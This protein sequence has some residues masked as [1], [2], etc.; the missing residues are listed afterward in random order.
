LT[1][2]ISFLLGAGASFPYGVPMMAG[3]YSEFRAHVERRHSHCFAL[4]R[5]LEEHGGHARPDLETLLSDLQAVAGVETGLSAMGKDVSTLG[6]IAVARELRGYLDAFI[7]DQCERFDRERVSRELATLF[8]LRRVA[9]VWIFSTNYDRIVEYACEANGVSWSDGFQ[10]G[11]PQAVV[12]WCGMFDQ[13]IRLVKLHGSVNWYEDDPG[14][15]LHRLDRGYPLPAYDFRLLRG[16]QV[17]R[18]LMIIPT[19]E[20][21][22]LKKPYVGLAMRFTDLLKETR[23]LIVAGNSLRDQHIKQYIQERL[24]HLHVL[25]V[26][27]SASRNRNTFGAPDRTHALNAGFSEFLTLGGPAL[28]QLAETVKAAVDD[29]AISAALAVFITSVSQA[30]SDKS[31]V[32]GNPEMEALWKQLEDVGSAKRIDAVKALSKY[33]HPAI[34]RRITT[35]LE[36]DSNAAVRVAAVDALVSLASG[37]AVS[38]LGKALLEDTSEDVQMEAALALTALGSPTDGRSY[39]S[40]RL[41]HGSVSPALKS[42]LGE[43]LAATARA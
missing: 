42:M 13:E 21:G 5:T 7:V 26:S 22:A 10:V 31:V 16:N 43:A 37:E 14:G 39:L 40:Q 6:E 20:K 32:Q 36:Q 19:M 38:A 11:S 34:T 30:V 9:P 4:L 17:L 35:V 12:D 25:L 23:L 15:A 29:A 1:T 3:F 18:P 2:P 8:E 41:T 28:P 24:E 33:T 27:P